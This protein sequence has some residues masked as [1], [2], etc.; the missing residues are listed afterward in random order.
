MQSCRCPE[1]PWPYDRSNSGGYRWPVEHADDS[2][3][4]FRRTKSNHIQ[5]AACRQDVVDRMPRHPV[6]HARDVWLAK[7]LTRIGTSRRLAGRF[8][9]SSRPWRPSCHRCGTNC[10]EASTTAR[11]RRKRCGPFAERLD[12]PAEGTAFRAHSRNDDQGD[13]GDE[14]GYS[15]CADCHA[16][17]RWQAPQVMGR[18]H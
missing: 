10:C 1:A 8:T 16:R 17:P 9:V 18:R 2:G 11:P 3:I 4:D 14:R 12:V 13:Q 5:S 6:A 15:R 7:L